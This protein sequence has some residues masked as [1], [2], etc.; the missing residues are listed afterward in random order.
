MSR[1]YKIRD[2]DKL[3]FVTFTV[4]EW[5]DLF[6]RREY[7]DIFLDSLRYCQKFKG[8]DLC[9]YCIMSS[10]IHMILGRNGE[11]TL[12]GLMRDIKKFTSVKILEAIKTSH[13][14]SRKDIL[15]WHFGKAGRANSNNTHFQVWQ[16]HSHPIELNTNEKVSRCLH[17]IHQNPVKAGIVLSQEDY[18]Y[19]SAVNYAG[20]P[21]KLIDVLLI[22]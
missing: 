16:Q 2:Q 15:L 18:L 14:E 11:L 21:E 5:I 8:L 17:Y 10:H 12:Q 22:E 3:Y 7:R 1:K 9:A 6:T 19:S 20:L 4:I 13:T